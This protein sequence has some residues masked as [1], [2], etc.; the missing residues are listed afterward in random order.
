MRR[1]RHVAGLFGPLLGATIA[2]FHA[3]PPRRPKEAM[4]R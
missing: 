3:I 1:S 4:L 2:G